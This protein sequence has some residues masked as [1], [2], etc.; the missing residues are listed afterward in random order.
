[1]TKIFTNVFDD[2]GSSI[3]GLHCTDI[4]GCI[5]VF[6]IK[7]MTEDNLKQKKEKPKNIRK[8]DRDSMNLFKNKLDCTDWNKI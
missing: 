3:N 1:M 6:H 4:S 7:K 2:N 5:P 8:Y